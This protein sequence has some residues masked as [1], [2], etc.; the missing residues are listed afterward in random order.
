MGRG[1]VI[2]DEQQAIGL[3]LIE[4]LRPQGSLHALEQPGGGLGPARLPGLETLIARHACCHQNK[5]P[6]DSTTV[7][8]PKTPKGI[9]LLL[10]L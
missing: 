9:H 7:V 1:A 2:L 10:L 6:E 5:E 3:C 8:A 4:F